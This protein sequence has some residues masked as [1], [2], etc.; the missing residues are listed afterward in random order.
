MIAD[1]EKEKWQRCMLHEEIS[2][3]TCRGEVKYVTF[4]A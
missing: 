3:H 4:K 2:P 1:K